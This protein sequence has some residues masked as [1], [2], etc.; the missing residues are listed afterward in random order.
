MA[1]TTAPRAEI[2][3]A[4]TR[5]RRNLVG[6]ILTYAALLVGLAFVVI[7]LYWMI[8]T[9]L[10]TSSALFLLPPQIVP[11]PVQWQ[12]YVEVWQL[13]PLARY[14]ANSIFIT[15]LAMF[16]EILTCALVAYGFARFDFP[17]RNI[18]F[19][20]MLGTMMLPGVITLIPSFIIWARVLDRYDT[21]SPLTVGALFAW[22]PSYIFL[23]RQFFLTI[24]REIED[25]AT[26]DGANLI[27][28]FFQVMLPLVKPALLAVA[29]LS[30]N[31]NWNNFFSQLIYL[32]TPEHFGLPLG[33]YQFNSALSGGGEAPKWNMMMAMTVLMTIP[34]VLLYVRAQKYFIEG[35]TVGA[36][37]G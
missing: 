3:P 32:S 31:G 23:L 37:K 18:L 1:V 4:H 10:K 14:F 27:Q 34:V 28:T 35:I 6:S 9:S 26:I 21:F 16:G 24:P 25:A 17:G 11:Q 33:L 12:N 7:P 15:V 8:S 13:V 36:V 20:I 19:G 2:Q 22:G 5:A 30:F 29:V